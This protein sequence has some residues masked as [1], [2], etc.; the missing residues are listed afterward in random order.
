MKIP[1]IVIKEKRKYEFMQKVNDNLF[2]Y[3]EENL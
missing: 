2:L 1:K 3:R